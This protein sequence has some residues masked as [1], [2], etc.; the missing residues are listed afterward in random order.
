M[1]YLL[2]HNNCYI[3]CFTVIY[4]G[5]V[6]MENATTARYEIGPNYLRSTGHHLL[7]K[8]YCLQ[9]V[10]QTESLFKRYILSRNDVFKFIRFL[11]TLKTRSSTSSDTNFYKL[12]VLNFELNFNA[13]A[14][15]NDM[16]REVINITGRDEDEHLIVY[17]NGRLGF[18]LPRSCSGVIM[19]YVVS[20]TEDEFVEKV[21]KWTRD[22][23]R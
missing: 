3:W 19:A 14:S 6:V 21:L 16:K 10:S 13:M 2:F 18:Y 23:P 5:G 22:N 1:K 7:R 9:Y 15:N 12:Q 20:T 17:P 4:L 8:S 11:W